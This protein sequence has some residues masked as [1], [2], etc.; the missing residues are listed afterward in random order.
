[1]KL[2]IVNWKA[3]AVCVFA[4]TSVATAQA[5]TSSCETC[6]ANPDMFGSDQTVIVADFGHD[7]HREAGISCQGC[8]GG[9][10]DPSLSDDPGAAMDPD[11]RANPY[12]GVPKRT[13]V[14]GFC[15]KCHSDPDYMRQFRPDLRVDQVQEYWTSRHG[16]ALKQG[17]TNVATCTDCH[18]SH[19][20]RSA[21]DTQSRVYPKN[22]AETFSRCHSDS[23]R[24]E[25][26]RLDNGTPIPTN[27]LA[28][29]KESVHAKALLEKQ[30]L[31]APTCNDCHGNHGAVPPGVESISYVCGQCHGREATLF[32]AS[33]KLE[34]FRTHES[35]AEEGQPLD[36]R[37][38]HEMPADF[39]EIEPVHSL[40]ECS[41]CHGNHGVV[42]PTISMLGPLPA[43][44]CD[45]CHELGSGSDPLTAGLSSER[46]QVVDQTLAG[47]N[48]E[49]K[50]QGLSEGDLYDWLVQEAL[51]LPQHSLGQGA[52]AQSKLRPEFALLF[53]KLRVGTM[54][55]PGAGG[56]V[57]KGAPWRVR[58]NQCHDAA[59]PDSPGTQ[60]ASAFVNKLSRLSRATAA[61]ERALLKA[62]RG[63]V[64]TREALTE[65][66]GAVEA[67]IQ[68][69]VLVHSF[70]A[71]EKGE[72]SNKYEEGMKSAEA[73]LSAGRSALDELKSR[74]VGLLV[75]LV[76]I[77]L[78]LIGLYAKIR[79]IG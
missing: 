71:D 41:T 24:M 45:F 51:Q 30:D 21:T 22:V 78:T 56:T 15:G 67:S 59:S 36:C 12:H 35:F 29:W 4:V 16:K 2:R 58:C 77:G 25:K 38:C 69:Q 60:A 43:T 42:R 76:F 14:P 37:G 66:E 61:A 10:P 39:A 23:T 11:F 7:I 8:H 40:S 72:F 53:E 47:L 64:E 28:R 20:I 62:R 65:I 54:H 49:A 13:D 26:Y 27:Q 55:Q 3:L 57:V 46:P 68:L 6:H 34:G 17:D 1:M 32:R 48:A 5:P 50:A 63:G 33:A 44:P 52:D 18:G 9:N 75:S 73:G 74:R 19:G 31:S 70:S 79:Q